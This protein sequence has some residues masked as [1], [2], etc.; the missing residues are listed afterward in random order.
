MVIQTCLE[1]IN[2]SHVGIGAFRRCVRGVHRAS[3]RIDIAQSW[4]LSTSEDL[5]GELKTLP[6]EDTRGGGGKCSSLSL[7]NLIC[8]WL[9]LQDPDFVHRASSSFD[10]RYHQMKFRNADGILYALRPVAVCTDI[11][12]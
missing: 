11:H 5:C 2:V 6:P 10:L 12:E 3:V 7:C 4:S 8:D 9:D 1:C